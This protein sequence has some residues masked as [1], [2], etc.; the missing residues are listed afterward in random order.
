MSFLMC[1]LH[2]Y[3]LPPHLPSI[4]PGAF[5]LLSISVA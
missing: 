5:V 2:L 1:P 3:V 4:Y